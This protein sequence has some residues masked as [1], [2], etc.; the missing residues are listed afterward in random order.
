MT[1]PVRILQLVPAINNT[2]GVFNVVFNW[3]KHIDTAKIQFDYLYF[4]KESSTSR[5]QEITKLGG[6]CYF[7][8]YKNPFKFILHLIK[9]FK[10]NRYIILHSHIV[11]LPLIIFPIAKFFGVKNIIQHAHS[12]KWSN[13]KIN[14]WRNRLLFK[15]ARPWMQYKIA[16]SQQAGENYFGGDFSIVNNAVDTQQFVYRPHMRAAKRK[17]LGI[18]DRFV[19][20]HVGRFG[21]EK[22]HVFL[23][24]IFNE[25]LKKD[26]D[27][28]LLLAGN[29]PLEAQVKRQVT[30]LNLQDNVLFLGART[31]I[32]D[33]LQAMDVFCLP[34]LFEGFP[35]VG[36]EAQA[37]G[38]PFVFAD[39]I[40]PQIA[41]LPSSCR[42][43][44]QQ[45]A[46]FWA[47]KILSFKGVPRLDGQ[48][49]LLAKQFDIRQTT[50]EMEMLYLRLQNSGVTR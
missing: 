31:D 17:E 32:P 26:S 11:Q 10:G 30:E 4:I 3:H 25:V 14:S 22:N 29:G 35:V 34:S 38:M 42:L 44:L 9:F 45:P 40:T 46:E 47:D 8:S 16:C 39:T 1:N 12:S 19:I 28:C 37:A 43:S 48:A 5:E 21:L 15:L 20:G 36:V 50:K 2:G 13:K 41:L 23:V 49:I 18:E 6:K 27:A 7:L 24:N 33:L